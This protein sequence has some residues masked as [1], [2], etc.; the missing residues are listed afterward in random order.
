L[1][2]SGFRSTYAA[3]LAALC[4]AL[5]AFAP[6]RP[7]KPHPVADDQWQAIWY[8]FEDHGDILFPLIGLAVIALIALGIRRGMKSNV[9]ILQR[10]Q[11]QKDVIVRMMRAKLMV[12]AEAV[13]ND[14]KIDHFHAS[15]LLDELVKEGKLVEQKST[16][17]VANYRLK[18]L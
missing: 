13:A 10:K 1:I 17:G 6:R 18:G 2:P 9:A 5:L 16:G 7:H 11:D 14:L 12:S 15:A 8:F 4:H 3:V